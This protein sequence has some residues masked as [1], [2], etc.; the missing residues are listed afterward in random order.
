M[1]LRALIATAA[2]L[3]LPAPALA[4][5][6]AELSMMDDQL[7]LGASDGSVGASLDAFRKLGADR[8]RV[9]AF[10]AQIAPSPTGMRRPR[11]FDPADPF[12]RRY[13]W[14]DLDRVVGTAALLDLRVMISISTPAPFWATASPRR[15]NPVYRPKPSELAAFAQAVA[16]RY[17]HVAD[18][19]GLLNEPNQGAWLQPQSDRRGPVAPHLY[20]ALT[21]A[22]YPRIKA[23]D[24][25]SV[26]LL[27][28]LA[29]SGRDDP[30][31]TRPIRPLRFLRAMG[32]VDS[33]FRRVRSG[34]CR[35]FRPVPGD[36][37]GHHPYSVLLRPDQR[38]RDRD[39]AAIGDW[40]RLLRTIDGVRARGGIVSRKRRLDVHYTEF[41]YQTNPPDPFSGIPLARQDRYLQEAAYVA[42]RT[43]RVRALNQF[44]LTDGRLGRRGSVEQ[45]REFQSGLLFANGRAKPSL[46]HFP[47]PFVV[48]GS[49]RSRLVL[50]GQARPGGRHIVELQHRRRGSRTWTHLALVE[51]SAAGYF[52]R[53]VARAPGEYRFRYAGEGGRRVASAAVAVGSRSR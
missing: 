30:G 52:S 38:S 20:R 48:H 39:D 28:E 2:C 34:R 1:K 11:G 45:F 50:W 41:G 53:R 43:P 27:G 13:R 18:Q 10:W 31:A 33:R 37:I 19:Y 24:P 35:G 14:A 40:R 51:T 23:A 15:R 42:W 16:L 47:H 49:G 4:A 3:A 8:V 9:S 6:D 17:R 5:R 26:A 46:A 29:P 7:L 21:R 36:A 22:A 44:R 25:D 12:D 32:C